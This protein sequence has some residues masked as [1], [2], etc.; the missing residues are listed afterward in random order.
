MTSLGRFGGTRYAYG[1]IAQKP[2]M[3]SRLNAPFP[4]INPW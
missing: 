2:N 1:A 4:F 3:W